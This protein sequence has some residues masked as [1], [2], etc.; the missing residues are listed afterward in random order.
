MFSDQKTNG[1][2]LKSSRVHLKQKVINY[3]EGMDLGF[4]SRIYSLCTSTW[5][6]SLKRIPKKSQWKVEVSCSYKTQNP[7]S[8]NLMDRCV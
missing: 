3:R 8:P 2:E 1:L 5:T 6:P 7:D 4:L